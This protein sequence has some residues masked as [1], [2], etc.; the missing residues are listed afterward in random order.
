MRCSGMEHPKDHSRT[1]SFWWTLSITYGVWPRIIWMLR[2][3]RNPTFVIVCPHPMGRCRMAVGKNQRI[4]FH[5]KTLLWIAP[6]HFARSARIAASEVIN[7][8]YAVECQ[9]GRRACVDSIFDRLY[10][11][12][13]R[14]EHITHHSTRNYMSSSSARETDWGHWEYWECRL[15]RHCTFL[16]RTCFSSFSNVEQPKTLWRDLFVKMDSTRSPDSSALNVP[17]SSNYIGINLSGSTS[18][19]NRQSLRERESETMLYIV[20]LNGSG[21]F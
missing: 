14:Y 4:G 17:R 19:S 8:L 21:S 3:H 7:R 12:I 1:P 6:R 20:W 16:Y 18:I 5:P 2:T 10:H 9:W 13:T 11:I 15:R